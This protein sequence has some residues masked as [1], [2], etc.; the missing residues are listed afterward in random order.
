[1]QSFRIS[2]FQPSAS[3]YEISSREGI[4]GPAL[5]KLHYA[6]GT[7]RCESISKRFFVD[8][9]SIQSLFQKENVLQILKECHVPQHL[10]PNLAT[11][12]IEKYTKVFAILVRVHTP[13][14]IVNFV[15]NGEHDFRLPL[16]LTQ[17]ESLTSQASQFSEAQWEFLPHR[18]EWGAPR[19]IRNKAILPFINEEFLPALEGS[20]GMISK[21]TIEPGLHALDDGEVEDSTTSKV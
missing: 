1:M 3:I 15:E 6:L 13:E 20:A 16:E 12:I 17:L 9:N 8:P 14:A 4:M 19:T 18:F 5:D 11:L 10:I 21:V 2:R 7:K